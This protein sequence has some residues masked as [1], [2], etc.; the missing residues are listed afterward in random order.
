MSKT[1]CLCR[2]PVSSNHRKR[3]KLHGLACQSVKQL[4]GELA[5]VGVEK[6]PTL[7]DQEAVLC[8]NCEVVL[9]RINKLEN[10]KV[11][12]E[13]EIMNKKGDIKRKISVLPQKR[14]CSTAF[15]DSQIHGRMEVPT[16]AESSTSCNPDDS[17]QGIPSS[18][19]SNSAAPEDEVEPCDQSPNMKVSTQMGWYTVLVF[20]SI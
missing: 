16:T 11:K 20:L 9:K 15:P 13:E 8:S 4:L 12:I 3:K 10:D 6:F 19:D 17:G 7:R 18:D 5:G 14:P 1:C 2:E